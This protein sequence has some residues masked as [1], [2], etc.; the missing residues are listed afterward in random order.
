MVLWKKHFLKVK[1]DLLCCWIR[2]FQKKMFTLS[3]FSQCNVKKVY[4]ILY[5]QAVT[6]PS[7]N[8]TQP[9]LTSVIGRE[10]V[11]SRWYGRRHWTH[12]GGPVQIKIKL[13]IIRKLTSWKFSRWPTGLQRRAMAD[14]CQTYWML[15]RGIVV[16]TKYWVA[17]PSGL[18]R[19][20]KAPVSSEAWVRIPPL[21]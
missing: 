20:F 13:L 9:C 16:Q 19:W 6:H 17:W 3:S 1:E 14:V 5:S 2:K 15:E 10:L 4:S 18:R 7:T 21:P 12:H 8:R 11:C